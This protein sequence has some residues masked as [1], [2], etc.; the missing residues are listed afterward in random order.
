MLYLFFCACLIPHNIM[1]SR[2]IHIVSNDRIFFLFKAD[3]FSLKICVCVY[4]H[5][6]FC[7]IYTT[8]SFTT[9]P[10]S[11]DTEIEFICLLLWIISIFFTL[12]YKKN[13]ILLVPDIKKAGIG[14]D[15]HFFL[16]NVDVWQILDSNTK[17]FAVSICIKNKK[18]LD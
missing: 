16:W 2:F 18:V 11:I 17:I 14:G 15:I 1:S 12:I 9:H 5:T 6:I 7:C 10:S 4:T 3:V 8:F 13:K